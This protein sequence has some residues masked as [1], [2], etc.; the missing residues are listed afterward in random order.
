MWNNRV[1]RASAWRG[2]QQGKEE[3]NNMKESTTQRKESRM[4]GKESR[5]WGK[6]EYGAQA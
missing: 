3:N 1:K 6:G 5:A 4:Q 2:K